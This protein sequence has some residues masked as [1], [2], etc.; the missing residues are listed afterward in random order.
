MQLKRARQLQ[1]DGK[2]TAAISAYD[3]AKKKLPK[4]ADWIDVFAASAAAAKGDTAEVRSRLSGV[5]SLIVA[6]YAWRV[7]VRA[8]ERA[9]DYSRAVFIAEEA[10]RNGAK[11][12]RA[13]AFYRLSELLNDRGDKS[14]ERAALLNALSLGS[15]GGTDAARR[16]AQ[17]E[18]LT[19]EQRLQVGRTLLGAGATKT[20]T[21]QIRQAIQIGGLSNTSE[22]DAR[23]LLGRQTYRAGD[24][25]GGRAALQKV[26]T[27]YAS[28]PG[29]TRALLFLA[30]LAQDDGELDRAA[31]L[32]TKTGSAQMRVG[33]IAFVR[34]D[35][36][37]AMR[38][39]AQL[40]NE[41]GKYWQA[42]SAQR[43]GDSTN[44][45]K[46]FREVQQKWPLTYYGISAADELGDSPLKAEL[47]TSPKSDL[48]VRKK[49]S[50]KLDRWELL[51]DAEFDEAAAFEL[52]RIKRPLERAA[53]YDLAEEL[54]E[55]GAANLAM[56]VGRDLLDRDEPWNRRLLR[57]MYPM[58]YK[59]LIQREAKARGLDPYF[60]A[61]VIRQESRF[62]RKAVS[63]VGAI[64]LMQ[65]MPATGKALRKKTGVGTV[66]KARLQEPSVN[67]KLGTKF[68]SDLMKMY[69]KRLDAVLVAYNAG[70]SRAYRWR[71]FPEFADSALFVERIPFE[72]T[73]EYVKV[74][75]SNASIYKALYD[76]EG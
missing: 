28:T 41:Q 3:A 15:E 27:D 42:L 1:A 70:P 30:D 23:F 50:A 7:R 9:G 46:L 35:Y 51:R 14:G 53:L 47:A 34:G 32:Y 6:D 12:K 71:G 61:A 65:V 57:I 29:A 4:V 19:G 62:N 48:V 49:L 10:A 21:D 45:K 59:T 66:T 22:A 72:E 16:L 56:G 58:P 39:F 54:S 8:W 69:D 44:A 31:E 13:A 73:R 43:L 37:S 55:R 60:V 26:I 68:L 75:L 18:G 25:D 64:G 76:G 33:G 67:L 11:P 20:G 36:K 38:T 2:Y 74:V 63:A 17:L 24:R 40:N 52:A 5:D